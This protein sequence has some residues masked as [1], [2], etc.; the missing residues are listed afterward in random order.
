MKSHTKPLTITCHKCGVDRNEVKKALYQ[1]LGS[2]S[3][4]WAQGVLNKCPSCR[5][6]FFGREVEKAEA[7]Q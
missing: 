7:E 6:Y 2:E 3:F 4:I 1:Q 5:A